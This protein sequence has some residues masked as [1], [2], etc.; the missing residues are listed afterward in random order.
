MFLEQTD[1]QIALRKEIRAY[2][3]KL[4]TPA[5]KAAI[6][7]REAG[8]AYKEIIRQIGHDGWLT[9]GWPEEYGGKGYGAQESLIFFE[10]TRISGA[11]FPFVT[12]NTVG[13]ALIAHGSEAHKAFFLPKISAGELHFS[14]GYTEPNSGTDLASL[15]TSAVLDGDEYVINGNKVY[16]TS[17]EAADYVFLAA[18]TDPDISQRHK[19][20]S[21]L[22]VSTDQPGYSFSPIHTVGGHRTNV[23]YY[24]N[25]RCPANMVAGEVNKGWQL[26]T[27][28]LNHE[29]VGLAAGSINAIVLYQAVLQW[30]RQPQANGRRP[31]DVAWVQT[32]LAEAQNILEAMRVM[33]WQA[34]WQ[35]D[36][37]EPDPAFSS[38]IKAASAEVVI[39]VY[40]LLIDIIGSQGMLQSGS[41]GAVLQG[42]LEMEYRSCQ[43]NTFGG[44][45]AEVMRDL[46]A[47]FGLDMKAY[48]RA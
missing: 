34:A 6:Q 40:R 33:N 12:V 35:N 9:V 7:D 37:G 19:G 21:I 44:G 47:R 20:I 10:E 1:K 32:A 30:S 27:S 43:I 31:I 28:Q 25:M 26:I 46:V 36:Q 39:E 42:E 5:K 18:R 8:D 48:K 23:T 11:P 2:F 38:A 14:I 17:A 4:M 16:T 15:T 29:R 3:S 41:A 45:V 24:D 22:M 13:P